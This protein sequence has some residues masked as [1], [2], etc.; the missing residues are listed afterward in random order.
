MTSLRT[1]D[2]HNNNFS[3]AIP[4]SLLSNLKSL[5]YIELSG[6]AFEGS[7]SLASL[8]NNSNLEVFRLLDNRNH[9]EVNTEDTTWFASFQL[10]VFSLS[11]CVLN[12]DANG[13]IPNF[14]KE[15][16]DLRIVQL[17]HNKMTGNFPSWLLDKNVKL[18]QFDLIGGNLSGAFDMASNLTLDKMWWF[19]VSANVIEGE[20][21]SGI[22]SI[23][24]N[25]KYLN[26]SNNLLKGRI[27]PSI[28]NV[29]SLEAL[30]LSNNG[31]VG[32]IPETLAKNC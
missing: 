27:P 25:L 18:E 9:M 5:E 24:P 20:L 19:D 32:G 3:G 12:K 17:S 30:D 1:L 14:L 26:L 10:K 31:F 29:K 21:P 22:G 16:Y 13:V 23:L 28:G 6:N 15:Q 8:A 11:N 2:V 7:L 4:S